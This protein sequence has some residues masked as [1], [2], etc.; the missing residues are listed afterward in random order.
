LDPY[1]EEQVAREIGK[2]FT[3]EFPTPATRPQYSPLDCTLFAD[4]FGICLPDWE[5]AL[6][7]AMEALRW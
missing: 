5:A 3:R 7:L 2:A 1:P 4:T 6:Q